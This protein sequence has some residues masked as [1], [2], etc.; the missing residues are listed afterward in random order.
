MENDTKQATP[1]YSPEARSAR[2][3]YKRKWNAAH[4]DRVREYGRRHW[5]KVGK[6]QKGTEENNNGSEEK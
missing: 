2:N 4:K 3:A 5:E 6:A 1:E